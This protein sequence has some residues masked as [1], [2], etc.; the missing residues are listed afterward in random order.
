MAFTFFQ[1]IRVF[2]V[3]ENVGLLFCLARRNCLLASCLNRS[4]GWSLLPLVGNIGCF[5]RSPIRPEN[6]LVFVFVLGILNAP[7]WFCYG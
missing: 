5:E 7:I 4:L 2:M 3:S 1:S 6:M